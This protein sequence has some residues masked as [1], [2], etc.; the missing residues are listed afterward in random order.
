[1]G[2]TSA[3]DGGFH[4]GLVPTAFWGLPTWH[5]GPN[6]VD[7]RAGRE[8]A[9]DARH[10]HLRSVTPALPVVEELETWLPWTHEGVT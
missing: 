1:M 4:K 2:P 3:L 5:Q 9:S 6:G 8:Q 10:E 7:I